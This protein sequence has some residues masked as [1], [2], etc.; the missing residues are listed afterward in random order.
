MTQVK[1]DFSK[2]CINCIEQKPFTNEEII[3]YGINKTPIN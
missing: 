2:F 1:E 3:T